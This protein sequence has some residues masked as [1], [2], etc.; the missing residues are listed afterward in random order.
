MN[1]YSCKPSDHPS[2][3]GMHTLMCIAV[4]TSGICSDGSCTVYDMNIR[5][6]RGIEDDSPGSNEEH[7]R[8]RVKGKGKGSFYIAQYP[9]RWTAQSALHFFVLS[10]AQYLVYCVS[11]G[12]NGLQNMLVLNVLFTNLRDQHIWYNCSTRQGIA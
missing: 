5:P 2:D 10:V 1:A 7:V 4:L 6:S 8:R 9:V 11:G 3:A 12:K